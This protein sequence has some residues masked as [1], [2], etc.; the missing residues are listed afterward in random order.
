VLAST[1]I[2]TSANRV[3]L[4]DDDPIQLRVRQTI[5]QEAGI[6][7]ETASTAEGALGLLCSERGDQIGAIVTD[8]IMPGLSGAIFV[9]Q[10]RDLKPNVPVIVV[11]GMA[12]AEDEYEGLDVTFRMK[13]CP[14]PELIALV[15]QRLADF[16]K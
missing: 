12:E 14:P 16:H 10:L 11:S 2:D 5:L 15:R 7:V 8:H 1:E 9:R 4:I 13:P 3:L 6:P